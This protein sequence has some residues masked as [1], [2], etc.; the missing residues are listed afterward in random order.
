MNGTVATLLYHD[1]AWPQGGRLG[2]ALLA[3]HERKAQSMLDHGD[4]QSFAF[5]AKGT[6]AATLR[7]PVAIFRGLGRNHAPHQRTVQSSDFLA[8]VG[9]TETTHQWDSRNGV[10]QNARPPA[11]QLFV[12]WVAPNF[13]F[14]AQWPQVMGWV[15][16]FSWVESDP[17]KPNY[18]MQYLNR[19]E[20]QLWP[21]P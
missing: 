7:Q 1:A 8:Y 4:I 10:L 12:V 18:P 17:R 21:T 13:D 6:V 3:L 14:K 19:Y 20:E 15:D 2:T 16:R 11:S 5:A 9:R